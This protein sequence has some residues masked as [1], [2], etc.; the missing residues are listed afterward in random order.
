VS[1]G[2]APEPPPA[3]AGDRTAAATASRPARSKART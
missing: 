1:D 3:P 2:V